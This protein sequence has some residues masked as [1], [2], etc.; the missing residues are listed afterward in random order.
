M[1]KI[2]NRQ[3]MSLALP[4]AFQSL[5]QSSLSLIDQIMVAGL[6]STAMAAAGLSLRPLTILF[7]MLLS[8]TGTLGIFVAQYWGDGQIE[9]ITPTLKHASIYALVILAPI[10][11]M[12]TIAPRQCMRLFSNDPDVISNGIIYLR[13]ISGTYIPLM[14]IMLLSSIMKSCGKVKLP[15]TAGI[16]AVLINTLL[17]YLLIYGN[18]PFPTL[19]LKGAAIATLIAR[20]IEATIIIVALLKSNILRRPTGKLSKAQKIQ[21]SKVAWPLIISELIFISSITFYAILYGRMGTHQMAAMTVLFPLQNIAFGIFAGMSTASSALVGQALGQ[22]A[23]ETAKQGA[24]KIMQ[25]TL[26]LGT[27]LALFFAII[28]PIYLDFFSLE[29]AVYLQAQSL[30]L[31]ALCILPFQIMNM[32]IYEGILRTGGQTSYL[33]KI[34]LLTLWAIGIPAGI[35]AGFIFKLP[36]QYVFLAVSLEEIIRLSISYRMMQKETWIARLT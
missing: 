28:L 15:M 30:I 33:V 3:I 8:V 26:F 24:K 18:G 12:T 11:F 23:F 2:N 20:I 31:I 32:V 13:I 19:G 36:L 14:L 27:G 29:N 34:Q 21:F 10:L 22:G 4:I 9:K 6:G 5:I 35:F 7:F 25:L 16:I 17:N 1:K